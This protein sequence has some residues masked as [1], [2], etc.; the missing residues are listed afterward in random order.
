MGCGED[1]CQLDFSFFFGGEKKFSSTDKTINC[2]SENKID[3]TE[4]LE[5]IFL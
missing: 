2:R 3:Q 4:H 5:N 1:T